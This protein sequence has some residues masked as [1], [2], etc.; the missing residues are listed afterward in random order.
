MKK[1]YPIILSV[2]SVIILALLGFIFSGESNSFGA[3]RQ[4]VSS[5]G[6]FTEGGN[7]IST[8][9]SETAQVLLESDLQ[10]KGLYGGGVGGAITYTLPASSTITSMIPN[11]GDSKVW[12]LHPTSTSFTLAAGVGFDLEYTSSTAASI[13]IVYKGHTARVTFLRMPTDT[14]GIGDIATLVEIGE[15]SD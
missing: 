11:V 8:T 7:L 12:Y 6:N 2:A 14:G 15:D 5:P 9:T 13:P 3:R 4:S 1:Y 10:A